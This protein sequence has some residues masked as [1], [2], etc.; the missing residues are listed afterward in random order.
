[1]SKLRLL[2]TLAW[3]MVLATSLPAW[4]ANI[5][6]INLDDPGVGFNDPTP[7]QPVGGNQGT[8]LGEQR[9]NVFDFAAD[10]WGNELQSNVTIYVGATFAPLACSPTSG[11]LGS[12]GPTFVFAN[13]SGAELANTWYSSAL[14]DSLAGQDLAPGNIDIISF[15]NGD[16]GVNPNCFSGQNW[17]NGFDHNNDPTSEFDLLTV[18]MHEIAHGLGFLEF[19]SGTTGQL[20]AGLPDVYTT[21]ML[22]TTQGQTWPELTDA[23][24]LASQVNSGNLVWS[25]EAVTL[26]APYVLGPRPSV[27]VGTPQALQGSYEARSASFGPPLQEGGGTT[28]KIVTV[29]NDGVGTGT[30]GCEPITNNVNGKLALIDRGGCSFTQKVANAQ[31][32][33]AKGAIIVNNQPKG[34]PPMGG[35]DPNITIPSVGVSQDDGEAFKAAAAHNIVGKL[36]LD[37]Q[38]LA[39]ANVDGLV[40][41]YAPDPVQPGSS[42]SHWDTSATPNLLMEPFA[43]DDLEPTL[44]LDLTPALLQDIGW[45]LQ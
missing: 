25:G 35:S 3:T 37:N 14:A 29:V 15:F 6:V 27:V 32:A 36:L 2:I 31:A 21:H 26:E 16:I 30:D 44:F 1:M 12:A 45:N 34:L 33:G 10:S 20:L 19:V 7:V 4:S 18:V 41:L 40:K 22:D 17:Y 39:G 11:I 8:T 24:R 28:G 42:K 13:F 23:E 38:F 43:T 9:L 5:V